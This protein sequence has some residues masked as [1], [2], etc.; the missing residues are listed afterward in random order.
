LAA[1]TRMAQIISLLG[2]LLS[3]TQSIVSLVSGKASQA[4]TD[5][6]LSAAN[7][8][9]AAINNV[10]GDLEDSTTGLAAIRS[11]I[12]TNAA[13]ATAQYNDLVARLTTTQQAGSPVTLPT[14]P[15]SGYGGAT[16]PSVWDVPIGAADETAR[17]MLAQCGHLVENMLS[18][19]K[20]LGAKS[21][22]FS[23]EGTIATEGYPFVES[24]PPTASPANI[25]STDN[26]GTWLDR[27]WPS[28]GPL[29]WQYDPA[30]DSYYYQ[31]HNGS[32]DL[33]WRC[34]ITSEWF[35]RLQAAAVTTATIRVPPIWPGLAAVTLGS[36]VA[37]ASHVTVTTP[38]DGVI[39]ALT[40]VP[41]DKP[42]YVI[43]D[44]TSVAHIGQVA[45]A[46]DNGD[47]EFPQNFAF[48]SGLYTPRS[49]VR[50]AGCKLRAVQGVAG[51]VTPWLITP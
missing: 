7:Y 37:L 3:L 16:A 12:D 36:P 44:M 40:A 5:L 50:A 20:I 34:L 18:T 13:L 9:V 39:I 35:T 10:L 1:I 27:E 49:M 42:R 46:S 30:S 6:I 38:M 26:R 11:Q 32:P 41:P 8:L 15:P 29:T 48:P 47:V 45:F 43:G 24:G 2:D 4:T 21:D 28:N 22:F 19:S 31:D 51:T 33:I 25:L 14:S 17:Y 23:L